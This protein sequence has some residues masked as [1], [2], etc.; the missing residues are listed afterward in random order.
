MMDGEGIVSLYCT[1]VFLVKLFDDQSWRKFE[2]ISQKSVGNGVMRSYV[3]PF[4][5]FHLKLHFKIHYAARV[6]NSSSLAQL[7]TTTV[8]TTIYSVLCY[9]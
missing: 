3:H 6:A 9:L 7:T 8:I 4:L 1:L 5:L 2:S